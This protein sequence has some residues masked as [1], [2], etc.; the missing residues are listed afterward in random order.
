MIKRG[1]NPDKLKEVADILSAGIPLPARFRD[2][3]LQGDFKSCRDCH[4]EPDWILIYSVAKNE[5]IF[6]RTGTHSDL[7]KK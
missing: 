3:K 2:H 4:L 1:K 7:F 5:I 6:E